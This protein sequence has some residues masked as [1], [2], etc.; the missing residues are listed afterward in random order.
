[1]TDLNA[2]TAAQVFWEYQ[3]GLTVSQIAD[4]YNMNRQWVIDVCARTIH[5]AASEQVLNELHEVN[6][7][8][9]W[10]ASL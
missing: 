1:M 8:Q 7:Q 2:G 5:H 6:E 9:H 10:Q 4:R 3:Q